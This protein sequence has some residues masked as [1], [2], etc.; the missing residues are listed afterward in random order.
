MTY[1]IYIKGCADR[2][3][4]ASCAFVVK[5]EKGECQKRGIRFEDFIGKGEKHPVLPNKGQFQMELY[6]LSWAMSLVNDDDAVFKVYSNNMAVVGWVNKWDVPDD[7][8]DLMN[9]CDNI[10][11]GRDISAE[12]ISKKS[13]VVENRLV[14]D[15]AE[16]LAGLSGNMTTYV[17]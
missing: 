15:A 16:Y 3:S 2:E 11:H 4:G 6:A 12:H 8:I 5:D 13:N 9:Y 7:Y 14:N 17:F 1:E 10:L